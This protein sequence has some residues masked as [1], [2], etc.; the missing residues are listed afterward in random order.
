MFYYFIDWFFYDCTSV[1]MHEERNT[2][3]ESSVFETRDLRTLWVIYT[4]LRYNAQCMK[5][6]ALQTKIKSSL[7]SLENYRKALMSNNLVEV[8]QVMRDY[9]EEAGEEAP[10][11]LYSPATERIDRSSLLTSYGNLCAKVKE[12]QCWSEEEAKN[13][14]S[15]V[16]QLNSKTLQEVQSLMMLEHDQ[17]EIIE[18]VTHAIKSDHRAKQVQ[19]VNNN[20]EKLHDDLIDLTGM[21]ADTHNQL[22][23]STHK[24][25]L[26][27]IA[28]KMNLEKDRLFEITKD[29]ENARQQALWLAAS[30]MMQLDEDDCEGL[31]LQEKIK[32]HAPE[33]SRHRL[34]HI[35][36]L[37]E[38]YYALKEAA[39]QNHN[40]EMPN[41]ENNVPY[42]E[43]EKL[44]NE[45]AKIVEEIQRV[46][47]ESVNSEVPKEQ[48]HLVELP[49]I[50]ASLRQARARACKGTKRIKKQEILKRKA[51]RLVKDIYFQSRKLENLKQHQKKF[52]HTT[53]GSSQY[54]PV[55]NIKVDEFQEAMG[56]AK[57]KMK[58]TI[59]RLD[60][61]NSELERKIEDEK[62]R[63][64]RI[65]HEL[66]SKNRVLE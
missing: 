41:L 53:D 26:G 46:R 65:S 8:N 11:V 2:E 45:N 33:F 57:E 23:K 9:L 14:H 60:E 17:K 3:G 61:E 10:E 66:L 42:D 49:K 62:S 7:M 21:L 63:Y 28:D 55:E 1:V 18:G 36:D 32:L 37:L 4:L 19:S 34:L 51:L 31:G 43:H 39:K 5:D 64:K 59:M 44:L 22:F 35:Y 58:R 38:E 50:V 6:K 40:R 52:H 15:Q 25:E 30:T 12:N 54:P 13:V 24:E 48:M 27:S 56:L 16:S 20:L 29:R 47:T